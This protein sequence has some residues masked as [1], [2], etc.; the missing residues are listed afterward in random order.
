MQ[1]RVP[2]PILRIPMLAI[3]LNREIHEQGFKPN[4]QDHL[5][6]LLATSVKAQLNGQ[7]KPEKSASD[8]LEVC[9]Q[10]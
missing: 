3:H 5:S 1:V 10:I 6:P 9:D 7:H 4:K 8:S 2:R